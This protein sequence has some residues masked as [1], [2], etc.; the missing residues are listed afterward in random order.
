MDSEYDIECIYIHV[1]LV[2]Y[3]ISDLFYSQPGSREE[4]VIYP[5]IINTSIQLENG[6]TPEQLCSHTT[7]T[8]DITRD[9]YR[10]TVIQINDIG[11]TSTMYQ[12][13]ID[14][15]TCCMI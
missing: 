11:L 12:D 14:S 3:L 6:S 13:D 4:G 7:C 10:L 8:V 9:V 5:D 1:C 2:Y 15:K